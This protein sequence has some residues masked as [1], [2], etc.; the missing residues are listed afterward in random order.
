MTHSG[1]I[2]R[3]ERP[4]HHARRACGGRSHDLKE[5]LECGRKNQ[6]AD[7]RNRRIY[8]TGIRNCVGLAVDPNGDLWCSTNE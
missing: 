8:A 3:L 2:E 1:A 4:V 6:G 7:G 5:R